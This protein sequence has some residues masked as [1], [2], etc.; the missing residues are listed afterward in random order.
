M[1]DLGAIGYMLGR[2]EP[3]ILTVDYDAPAFASYS[4]AGDPGSPLQDGAGVVLGAPSFSMVA[5]PYARTVS[6][7]FK[8]GGINQP[9]RIVRA[10]RRD[11]GAMVGEAITD[12]S[13]NYSIT[14]VSYEGEVT[15]LA[16]DDT[17]TA[18]D[19]NALLYDRVIPG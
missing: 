10:F 13:G 17:G 15:V 14:I 19:Y 11:N 3:Q 16:Y 4:W 7:N 8:E 5:A 2:A 1:A 9:G 18:P 12:A 6:G